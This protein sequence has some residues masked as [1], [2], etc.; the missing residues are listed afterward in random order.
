MALNI[1]LSF[2]KKLMSQSQENL[3]ADGRRD[4]QILFY[5]TLPAEAR[6]PNNL[7]SASD[8]WEYNQSFFKE[9]AMISSK[10]ST[11]QENITILRLK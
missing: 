5:R 4:S 11:T 1:T 6:D 9:N 7:S 8:W 10:N 3:Q 2:R